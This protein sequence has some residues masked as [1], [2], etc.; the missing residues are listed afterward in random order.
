[1]PLKWIPVMKGGSHVQSERLLLGGHPGPEMEFKAKPRSNTGQG[2]WWEARQAV[3]QAGRS[4]PGGFST[5][6]LPACWE[7]L[8]SSQPPPGGQDAA[9]RLAVGRACLY[10]ALLP[11]TP[12]SCT[13]EHH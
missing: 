1:M 6:P 12:L 2:G 5:P 8:P 10:A 13:S 3:Q 4:S 11:P 9:V 7:A